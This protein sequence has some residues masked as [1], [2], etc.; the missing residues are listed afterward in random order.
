MANV[1]SLSQL[2]DSM[3]AICNTCSARVPRGAK[4]PNSF[5]RDAREET[6]KRYANTWP[7]YQNAYL[8]S[9]K[10]VFCTC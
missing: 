10:P 1:S 9:V 6:P 3:I 2:H 4:M 5:N 8:K 7:K